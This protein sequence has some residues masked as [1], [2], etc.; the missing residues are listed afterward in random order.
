M[1]FIISLLNPSPGLK[2]QEDFKKAE[3]ADYVVVGLNSFEESKDIINQPTDYSSANCSKAALAESLEKVFWE[4]SAATTAKKKEE[5]K[6]FCDIE[7]LSREDRNLVLNF[8][9]E[10]KSQSLTIDSGNDNFLH[11]ALTGTR[12]KVYDGDDRG[13]TFGFGLNYQISGTNGEMKLG[14]E[15]TGF[16]EMMRVG[17][18]RKDNNNHYYLN[19][20]EYNQLNLELNKNFSSFDP[21][22]NRQRTYLA[23][24]FSFYNET[25]KGNLSRAIQEKYHSF[26]NQTL[27]MGV[28]EYNYQSVDPDR[29]AV[30]AKVGLGREIFLDLKNWKCQMKGE[31]KAGLSQEVN[32]KM[33]TSHEVEMQ[34]EASVF[35]KSM[36][37][38][39]L[40]S[41]LQASSGAYG[42]EFSYNVALKGHGKIKRV[43]VEPFIG[44]EKHFTDRDKKF[45]EQG[46]NPNE[47]YH[48]LGVSFKF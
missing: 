45:D 43:K 5:V 46:G 17:R 26:A 6:C 8:L 10:I 40:S 24:E 7:S 32:G 11:G 4:E 2:A 34:A 13:R 12:Y 21:E 25:D 47:F 37:W 1:G 14:L 27:G 16:G 29:N 22:K 41:W 38:I 44:V 20:R 9:G 30:G 15:S 35:H 28:I 3:I 48:K 23:T 36:P 31:L 42:E 18:A 33:K 39:I 19:F